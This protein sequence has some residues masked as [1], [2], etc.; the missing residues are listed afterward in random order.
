[1]ENP[2]FTLDNISQLI[3]RKGIRPSIQRIKV[4][5]YFLNRKGHPNAEEIFH[6]L[7]PQ[8]PSLSKA[9]IYNTLH[10]FEQAGIL[11]ALHIDDEELRYDVI[12]EPHGHFKCTCCGKIFNFKINISDVPVRELDEF[13][14][15]E[16]NVFFK[17]LCPSCLLNQKI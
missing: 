4:L 2:T 10:A 8:I 1:M 15:H 16:K 11:R 17:G 14:I 12:M 7:A 5:E 9:T 13:Q 3:E 6:Y